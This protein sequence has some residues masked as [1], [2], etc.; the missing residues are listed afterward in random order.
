LPVLDAPVVVV[1]HAPD[2]VAVVVALE[3][4]EVIEVSG[5]A[6]RCGRQV[7]HGHYVNGVFE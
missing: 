1:Q 6:L 3:T 2:E 7:G 5:V 4:F